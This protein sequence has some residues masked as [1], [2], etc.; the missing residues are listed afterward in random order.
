MIGYLTFS[1]SLIHAFQPRPARRTRRE[2]LAVSRVFKMAPKLSDYFR[3]SE[4][5]AVKGSLDR[6]ISGLAIDSRRVVPGMLFFA[7][8]GRRADGANFIDEAVSRGAVA[9]VSQT[10]PVHPPGK[11]TIIQV[12]DARATLAA[13][14]QRFFKYPDRDM[15]VVGETGTNG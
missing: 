10:M 7:L 4:V 2:A 14:S 8:P 13:V 12:A 3:D 11:A 15:T 6:P 1:P 9:V 5:I